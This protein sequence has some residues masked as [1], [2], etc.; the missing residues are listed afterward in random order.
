MK[1]GIALFLSLILTSCAAGCG[2]SSEKP[3]PGPTPGVKTEKK[4]VDLAGQTSYQKRLRNQINMQTEYRRITSTTT[5]RLTSCQTEIR[6]YITNFRVKNSFRVFVISRAKNICI[7]LWILTSYTATNI[8]T[9]A[10][11]RPTRE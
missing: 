7:T 1:K 11:D 9:A 8:I 5:E 4:V 6:I 10:T 2:N 3:N